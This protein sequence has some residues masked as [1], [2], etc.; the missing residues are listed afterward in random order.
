M[1]NSKLINI[2]K[3]FIFLIIIGIGI[4]ILIKNREFLMHLKVSEIISFAESK[5]TKFYAILI[6]LIIFTVKPIFIVIPSSIIAIANGLIFGPF[7]GFL[8]T[9][10]GNFISA[11]IGFFLARIL[12]KDFVQGILGKKFRNFE[13]NIEKKEFL[14]MMSLRMIPVIPLDPISY[15]CGLSKISYKKFIAATLMGVSPETICYSILGENFDKPFSPQF[16]IPVAI[17]I[18]ALLLSGR[19]IKKIQD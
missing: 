17:L 10:I 15:A 9:M 6:T 11:T 16:I 2:L 5:N 19:I 1:K 4:F 14:I 13:S 18:I 3:F 7:E 8:V 12:G